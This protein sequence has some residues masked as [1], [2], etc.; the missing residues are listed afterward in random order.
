MSTPPS[1]GSGIPFPL[2]VRTTPL[3]ERYELP[4]DIN[5]SQGDKDRLEASERRR[6]IAHARMQ[7]TAE[8][9][10]AM[11]SLARDQM[12]DLFDRER[13][14]HDDLDSINRNYGNATKS[15]N[16]VIEY[17]EHRMHQRE[18]DVGNRSVPPAPLSN[19]AS[20]WPACE[21]GE[22][23]ISLDDVDF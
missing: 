5:M 10:R 9:L 21:K 13:I 3:T 8:S 7:H 12:G 4:Q 23:R 2:V 22:S 16:R 11:I 19:A 17:C 6:Y 14:L 1:T 18:Y 15:L 20:P